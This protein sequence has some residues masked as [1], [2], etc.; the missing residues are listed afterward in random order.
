M[1]GSDRHVAERH[2]DECNVLS[3]AKDGGTRCQVIE[4]EGWGNQ[5]RAFGSTDNFHCIVT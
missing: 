3:E 5:W 4:R 2:N 1:A